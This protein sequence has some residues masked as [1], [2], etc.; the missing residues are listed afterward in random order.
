MANTVSAKK[1]VRKIAGRTAVNKSNRS[2]MRNY[3]RK[4]EEAI[5]AGD[6]AEAA[7]ALKT[8][9]PEIMKAVSRGILKKNAA[10]RKVSRL[11]KRVNALSAS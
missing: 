8:A 6:Q 1:S 11:A 10:A 2:R 3:V 4:T 5:A 7:E 9:Q